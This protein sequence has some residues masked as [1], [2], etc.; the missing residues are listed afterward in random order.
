[1]TT[2]KRFCVL[3]G[4]MLAA[5]ANAQG[6]YI[7]PSFNYGLALNKQDLKLSDYGLE[8]YI[9]IQSGDY[10][11]YGPR[12]ALTYENKLNKELVPFG[13]GKIFSLELGYENK[14]SLF[15]SINL[16]YGLMDKFQARSFYKHSERDGIHEVEV[17]R[18]EINQ[19]VASSW[20]GINPGIG[21]YTNLGNYKLKIQADA[22]FG[23]AR[24]NVITDNFITHSYSDIYHVHNANLQVLKGGHMLGGD[25]KVCLE[26]S[27]KP[28]QAL[29]LQVEYRS[30]VY[31]PTETSHPELKDYYHVLGSV[32]PFAKSKSA[33]DYPIDEYAKRYYL[34]ESISVGVYWK[35]YLSKKQSTI[36]ETT[37]P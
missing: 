17:E 32:V 15:Y 33:K 37:N 24:I 35:R 34:F 23:Y 21:F 12:E 20:Y 16:S 3:L 26:K 11:D 19:I 27:L 2:F 25:L 1:M 10:F 31:V 28:S 4:W 13:K 8:N 36:T 5:Q 29:G 18:R 14:K 7:K 30:Q 9:Y 6:L 22:F